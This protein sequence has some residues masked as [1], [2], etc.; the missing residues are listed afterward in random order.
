MTIETNRLQLI[1]CDTNNL[2]AAIAGNDHLA[3]ALSVTVQDHWTEFGL[4][5]LQFTLDRLSEGENEQGWWAYFII[6]KEENKLIG[7]GGY[8][9]QPTPDGMVEIG[10]EIAPE[11]RNRGLATEMAK[12]LIENA[13]KDK[14]VSHIIAHTLGTE[15]PS[16]KVL[17]KCGFVK[18]EEFNDPDEG[19]IWKWE[20]KK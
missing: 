3:E 14:R 17:L 5:A 11:Y 15:N 4:A 9:G 2:K 19:L 6:L 10:Y 16:T 7:S 20:L 12:G 1:S 13:L 8:K 18:T